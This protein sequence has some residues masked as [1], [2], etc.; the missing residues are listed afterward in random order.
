MCERRC[1]FF[2]CVK[3]AVI[4]LGHKRKQRDFFWVAKKGLRDL[5]GGGMLKKVVIFLGGQILKL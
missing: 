5:G 3:D 2:G 1:D 4:F